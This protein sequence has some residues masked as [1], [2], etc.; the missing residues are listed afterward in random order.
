MV[1]DYLLT[2]LYIIYVLWQFST[3]IF[4]LDNP[5][6][7]SWGIS[8]LCEPLKYLLFLTSHC[9]DEIIWKTLYF[10][11]FKKLGM[12]VMT[13]SERKCFNLNMN[14]GLLIEHWNCDHLIEN[15]KIARGTNKQK[16]FKRTFGTTNIYLR[17]YL[18]K[19]FQATCQALLC[20]ISITKLF[21]A[22]I[23]S[24]FYHSGITGN[25]CHCMS[26]FV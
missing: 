24:K 7:H 8:F 3:Y 14:Y 18:T 1:T 19:T 2:T 21:R 16:R 12:K 13:I 15:L 9:T 6:S 22:L 11:N 26:Y 20:P 17:T 4:L 10:L 23:K 25:S 5:S